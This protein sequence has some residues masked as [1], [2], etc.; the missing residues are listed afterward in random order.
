MRQNPNKYRL[1][2]ENG[3]LAPWHET[4]PLT[5]EQLDE[6]ARKLREAFK[7]D[8]AVQVDLDA[9]E[10]IGANMAKLGESA[11]RRLNDE[12]AR[13]LSQTGDDEAGK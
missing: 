5:S 4:T 11:A 6:S 2:Q 9:H 7:G 1:V 8:P 10:Q 13:I 3:D 12:F